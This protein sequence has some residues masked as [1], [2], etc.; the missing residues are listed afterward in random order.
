[1]TNKSSPIILAE[2]P[3]D[4][5]PDLATAQSKARPVMARALVDSVRGLLSA[6]VLVVRDGKIIPNPESG[7]A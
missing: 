1:M 2:M 3:G 6:G 7:Q 5:H 4:N